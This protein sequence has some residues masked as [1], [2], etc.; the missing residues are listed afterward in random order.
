MNTLFNGKLAAMVLALSMVNISAAYAQDENA[1]AKE[2]GNR[3]VMLNAASANGPREI[4]I[5]LPSADVNVLETACPLPMPPIP[6]RSTPSGAA[7][8]A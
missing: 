4:Q 8:P 1:N 6:T 3:N 7:M 5:G 2:E